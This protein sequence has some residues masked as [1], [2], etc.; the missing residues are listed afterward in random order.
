[1]YKT[2]YNTHFDGSLEDT[3]HASFNLPEYILPKQT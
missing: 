3:Q 2:L 1:M